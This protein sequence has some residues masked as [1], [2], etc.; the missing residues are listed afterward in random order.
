MWIKKEDFKKI[1]EELAFLRDQLTN[2]QAT[3]AQTPKKL[4]TMT[5]TRK[6][7]NALHTTAAI[8]TLSGNRFASLSEQEE[9]T[10]EDNIEETNTLN[11]TNTNEDKDFPALDAKTGKKQ[12]RQRKQANTSRTTQNNGHHGG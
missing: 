1:M 9:D 12:K 8:T 2:K 6:Q 11:E 7:S 3:P 10:N 4:K 5:T